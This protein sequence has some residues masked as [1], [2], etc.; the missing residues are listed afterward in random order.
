MTVNLENFVDK[1]VILTLDSGEKVETKIDRNEYRKPYS[2]WCTVGEYERSYTKD[3][4]YDIDYDNP[5]NI[6]SI[7][8]KT[9]PQELNM[10]KLSNQTFQK[11]ADTLTAEVIDCI[12]QDSRYVDF[13]QEVIPD[14]LVHLMGQLDEDLKCELSMAIMDRIAL[15]PS[16]IIRN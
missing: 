16:S 8:L 13:M 12:E 5:Y 6:K 2:Y 4:L 10:T 15:R 1:E 11:L 9:K 14:A 3:G 7:Q